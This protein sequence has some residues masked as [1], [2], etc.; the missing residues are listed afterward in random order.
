MTSAIAALRRHNLAD[1]KTLASPILTGLAF[2][3]LYWQ[4]MVT[5]GNDWWNDP[6]AG[7]GLLLFPVAVWLAW[8]SGWRADA[9]PQPILGLT[10]LAL[11][12]VLRY[13]SGLAA[14]LFT[15][16]ASLLGAAIALVIFLGGLRQV[17]H[18][19]LP[20]SLLALSV[21]I[22][23][24][25]LSSIALPLQL[26]AS[27][28]GAWLLETRHVPVVLSGNVIHLPERSLFVTEACSGL[29]SLTALLAL[30][31]LIGGL[32]LR[33]PWSR[34]A[35]AV[36]AVPVAMFLNG[37]RVF[38][39]GFLVHFVSPELGDGFMHYTEGWAMFVVAFAMLGAAAWIVSRIESRW[40]AVPA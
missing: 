21:P 27:Q 14:E 3:V 36:V 20:I 30:A 34:L 15:M 32:W 25:L 9:K 24:V 11:A 17:W 7:H 4:P 29:R 10:L 2:L 23:D 19:W 40:K 6:E 37:L 8:R 26:K 39:T 35:I 28:M 22:P 33:S 16:R 31:L 13:L 5:L 38:L 18:W 1:W 12:V